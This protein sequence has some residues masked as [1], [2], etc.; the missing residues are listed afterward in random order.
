MT[1]RDIL[2]LI[3]SEI[4][5][6]KTRIL[7][8]DTRMQGLETKFHTFKIQTQ[9]SIS[10]LKPMDET[11]LDEVERVHSILDKHKNDTAIHMA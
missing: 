9:K 11:I 6:M 8:L 7:S 1:D 5:D 10:E 4:Q 2:N 3:L